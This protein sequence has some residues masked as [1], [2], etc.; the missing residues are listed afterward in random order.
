MNGMLDKDNTSE[1][2]EQKDLTIPADLRKRRGVI[3]ISDD[4]LCNG[5]GALLATL[6]DVLVIRAEHDYFRHQITLMGYSKHFEPMEDQ[7][8]AKEYTPMI[9]VKHN[10]SGEIAE[11]GVKWG[12]GRN[13]T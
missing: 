4:M 10:D 13:A 6:R 8:D 2:K 7:V 5:M 3:R 12:S 11:Y 9:T 1:L